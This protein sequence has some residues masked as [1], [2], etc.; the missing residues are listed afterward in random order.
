MLKRILQS[1]T[2]MSLILTFG[3]ISIVSLF[4]MSAWSYADTFTVTNLNDSGDGSLRWAIGK[5]NGYS[6]PD[7]IDF[8][9]SGTISLLSAL[10]A[11]TDDGTVIDASSQWIGAWPSGQPGITLD[12]SGAG[13]V[14]GLVISGA[15]NCHIRGLFITNF[16]RSGVLI[17]DGGQFNIVGGTG[18]GYRNVISGNNTGVSL[19]GSETNNNTVSGNYIGTDVNGTA[20]LGNSGIGIYIVGG[21]QFNTIGGTTDGERNIISGN[22]AGVWIWNSGTDS[23]KV[24]GNYIG[25]DVN[26][27]SALGNSS[28]GVHIGDP[29][30]GA[31]FNIIERNVISGNGGAGVEITGASNNTVSGNYI[32]TDVT[33]TAALGNNWRGVRIENGAKSNTIGGTTPDERNIISGNNEDGISIIGPGADNNVVSGN[34]IGTDVN[35]IAD[36]GNSWNGVRI[37]NE[38]KSNIV[39]GT[40]AGEH[41]H[42]FKTYFAGITLF[43]PL[44]GGG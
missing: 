34:Y 19:V 10:P 18:E 25:T 11:I 41:T 35:G 4:L 44:N 32:G 22:G 2:L 33:G 38:A 14:D 21:P 26:G 12:G 15:D 20:A 37:C 3:L 17:G 28:H 36:P 7:T 6:G 40:T 16:A 5:A 30:L 8:T 23:N 43:L 42:Q 39:G 24:S 31:Q 29:G 1:G 13:D 9:V 27:T